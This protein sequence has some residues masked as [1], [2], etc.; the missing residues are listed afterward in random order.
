MIIVL[1]NDSPTID[2]VFIAVCLYGRQRFYFWRF[3]NVRGNNKGLYGPGMPYVY[4]I[5]NHQETT[6][7]TVRRPGRDRIP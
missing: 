1:K 7:A 2:N 4:R 3:D 6:L 5:S